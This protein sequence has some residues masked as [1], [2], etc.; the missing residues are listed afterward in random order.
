[1]REGTLAEDTSP[2]T[3]SVLLADD[4]PGVLQSLAFALRGA[5]HRVTAAEDGE[6][7]LAALEAGDFDVLVLDILM[8]GATGWEVL[9]RA[10]ERTPAGS[11]L[12]RAVLMTGFHQEYVVDMRVLRQEGVSAMLL[13][14]FPPSEVLDE[15]RRALFTVPRTSL[16]RAS[17]PAPG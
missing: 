5:G 6:K 9:A 7:A 2:V 4:D 12:P 10:V 15:V 8:P 1:L 16:P 13:K 14:P 11:P 3:A 17:E